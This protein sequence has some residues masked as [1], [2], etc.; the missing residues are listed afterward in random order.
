[1]SS[2]HILKEQQTGRER[3]ALLC[4]HDS[5]HENPS[6]EI[7]NLKT[8]CIESLEINGVYMFPSVCTSRLIFFGKGAFLIFFFFLNLGCNQSHNLT[9]VNFCDVTFLYSILGLRM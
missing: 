9:N 2:W 7:R 4:L 6:K 8:I 5:L 3:E 1:M